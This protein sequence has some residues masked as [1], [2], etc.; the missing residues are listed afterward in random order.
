MMRQSNIEYVVGLIMPHKTTYTKI[1]AKIIFVTMFL[2][3]IAAYFYGEYMKKD[4][5]SNLAHVDAKN[6]QACF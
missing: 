1:A 2:T 3:L 6:K 4:A 5:I